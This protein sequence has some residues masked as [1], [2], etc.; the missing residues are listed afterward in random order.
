VIVRPLYDPGLP[1]TNNAAERQL[2]HWVVAR[3]TS[4][5]TRSEQCSR[6]LAL[7]ASLIDTCRLRQAS[8]WD[9]LAEALAAGRKGLPMPALPGG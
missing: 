9:F 7:L 4:F 5:G 8:A 3:K 6:A 2:R 1:L